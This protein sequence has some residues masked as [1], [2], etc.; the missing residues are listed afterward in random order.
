MISGLQIF[1]SQGIIEM[2][3]GYLKPAYILRD[4]S[5][6]PG[7]TGRQ[8]EVITSDGIGRPEP[9]TDSSYE[10]GH[11]AAIRDLITAAE[12]QTDTRCSATDGRGIVEMTAAVFESHRLKRTV[13]LPLMTRVNPLSLVN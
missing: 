12:Q 10:G 8:W 3:S 1:G 13:D 2:Q 5:W 9:R 4:S 7:R 11:I 6:S